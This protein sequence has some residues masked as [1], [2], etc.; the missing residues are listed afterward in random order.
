MPGRSL[1]SSARQRMPQST[2]AK[3]SDGQVSSTGTASDGK[4]TTETESGTAATPIAGQQPKVAEDEG[5]AKPNVPQSSSEFAAQDKKPLP[6]L[7][8][9]LGVAQRPSSKKL[10]WAER[11][12]RQFDNELRLERR[13]AM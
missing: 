6:Y 4:V 2:D 1:H 12:E 5:E 10:T 11:R 8:A 9:P 3:A 7:S 13:K